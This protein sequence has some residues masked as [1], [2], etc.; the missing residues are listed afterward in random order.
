MI[1]DVLT[2]LYQPRPTPNLHQVA[3]SFIFYYLLSVCT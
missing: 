1:G 2:N 3:V